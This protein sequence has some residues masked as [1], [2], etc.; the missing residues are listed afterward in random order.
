MTMKRNTYWRNILIIKIIEEGQN[1][2]YRE[3]YQHHTS[4]YSFSFSASVVRTRLGSWAASGSQL[5][6]QRLHFVAFVAGILACWSHKIRPRHRVVRTRRPQLLRNPP[7]H[8]AP[9]LP[10]K[11]PKNSR[12]SPKSGLIWWGLRGVEGG[13]KQKTHRHCSEFCGA[14]GSFEMIASDI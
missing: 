1:L 11:W 5:C 13:W 9:V 12:L 7:R 8:H 6:Q 3:D 10:S 2:F 14:G 4:S